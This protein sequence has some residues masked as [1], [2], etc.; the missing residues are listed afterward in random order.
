MLLTAAGADQ[1]EAGQH[2]GEREPDPGRVPLAEH[3][4]AEQDAGQRDDIADLGGEDGPAPRDQPDEARIGQ[5]AERGDQ[6]QQSIP[7]HGS[8]PPRRGR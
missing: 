2:Q 7:H 3:G 8:P 4:H 5:E 6:R 1:G